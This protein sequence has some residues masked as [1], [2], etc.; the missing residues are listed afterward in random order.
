MI[1]LNQSTFKLKIFNVCYMLN[2]IRFWCSN[3]AGGDLVSV[4]LKEYVEEIFNLELLITYCVNLYDEKYVWIT[5]FWWNM[6]HKKNLCT[7]YGPSSKQ[8][9]SDHFISITLWDNH[10]ALHNSVLLPILV[11]GSDICLLY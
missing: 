9:H 1:L 3:R 8:I 5:F 2:F 4:L 7:S 11:Y 6:R 10:R